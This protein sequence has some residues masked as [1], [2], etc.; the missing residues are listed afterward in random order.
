MVRIEGI[1]TQLIFE[2]ALRIRV[3]EEGPSKTQ[4]PSAEGTAP[5]TPRSEATA[6]VSEDGGESRSET[7]SNTVP[8]TEDSSVKGDKPAEEKK[9][10]GANLVGKINNLMSTDLD[11][12]C[13]YVCFPF[14]SMMGD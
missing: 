6:V 8:A 10:P 13:K 2:H 5:A 1:I 14:C 9:D 3:K 12:I 7:D 11:K 4:G